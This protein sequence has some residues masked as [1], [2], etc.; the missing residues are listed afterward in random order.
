ME[1]SRK[2]VHELLS[3][4]MQ[5]KSHLCGVI[6]VDTTSQDIIKL[7]NEVW[8]ELVPSKSVHVCDI[9]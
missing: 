5:F 3:K 8:Q 1:P 2:M 6:H 4:L 9:P 7:W